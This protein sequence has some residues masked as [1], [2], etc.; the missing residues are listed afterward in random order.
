VRGLAVASLRADDLGKSGEE[1]RENVADI[2]RG[3]G[4]VPDDS[5]VRVELDSVRVVDVHREGTR[6]EVGLETADVQDKVG[7]LNFGLD[8]PKRVGSGVAATK[9][10]VV[11]VKEGL[12]HWHTLAGV[13]VLKLKAYWELRR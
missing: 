7:S 3:E 5:L 4:R 13:D 11:L 9:E 1:A 2:G 6:V 12:T 8:G 10:W